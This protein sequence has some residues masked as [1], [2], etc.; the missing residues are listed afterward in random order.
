MII[1]TGRSHYLEAYAVLLRHKYGETLIKFQH[2]RTFA[3]MWAATSSGLQG[4]SFTTQ[5][6][7]EPPALS[8]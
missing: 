5:P 1:E 6:G 8:L 2:E 3:T 4:S 7:H